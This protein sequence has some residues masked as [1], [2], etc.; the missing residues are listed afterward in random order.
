VAVDGQEVEIKVPVPER[1]F[2]C[3]A[4]SLAA[5]LNAP[6][7]SSQA[8]AYYTPTVGDYTEHEYPFKWLSVRTRAGRVSMNFKHFHPEGA[9]WHTH[10]DEVDVEVTD[11]KAAGRLLAGASRRRRASADQ[12]WQAQAT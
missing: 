4:A 7:V 3:L 2:T 10:A 11:A 9:E 1:Q 12:R 6:V 5:R 8:D